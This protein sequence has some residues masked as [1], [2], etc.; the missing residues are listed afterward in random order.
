MAAPFTLVS[1]PKPTPNGANLALKH[2]SVT[3]KMKENVLKRYLVAQTSTK[4]RTCQRSG[5]GVVRRNCCPKGCFW[6]IG[7]LLCP[8]LLSY[9]KTWILKTNKS[10]FGWPFLRTTPSLLQ[11][12]TLLTEG[13]GELCWEISIRSSSGVGV[14]EPCV[15]RVAKLSLFPDSVKR[16]SFS[17]V[18]WLELHQDLDDVFQF[19]DQDCLST[20]PHSVLPIHSPKSRSH[21]RCWSPLCSQKC[22]KK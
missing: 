14:L 13:L 1:S 18:D 8:L 6:R 4:L 10:C 5:E 20:C 2:P 15:V 17:I 22:C 7:F 12:R 19:V 11:W 3:Q 16:S 21:R 9:L